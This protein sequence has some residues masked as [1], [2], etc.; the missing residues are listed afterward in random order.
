[1]QLINHQSLYTAFVLKE[2]L[3]PYEK[4]STEEIVIFHAALTFII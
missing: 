2:L 3:Q 4:L 1:M